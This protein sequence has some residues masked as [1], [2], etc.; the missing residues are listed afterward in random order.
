MI[1]DDELDARLGEA[2]PARAA[3]LLAQL[4]KP[5]VLER[6]LSV[7]TAERDR[8]RVA[9]DRSWKRL[10]L[11]LAVAA[12]SAAGAVTAAFGV[13]DPIIDFFSGTP[14]T[15]D[16]AR[17]FAELPLGAPAG[18]DPRV[19]EGNV[20]RV[21][22]FPISTGSLTLWAGPAAAG[23]CYLFQ[24]QSGGCRQK[25]GVPARVDPTVILPGS[26]TSPFLVVGN[27]DS[28]DVDRIV[29][30]YSNGSEETADSVRVSRPIGATFFVFEVPHE[31]WGTRMLPH[32]VRA[33]R[34]DGSE[35]ARSTGALD[36]IS[37]RDRQI[38]RSLG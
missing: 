32:S 17:S 15:K 38:L 14:A 11:A 23:Y 3:T 4:A 5:V 30:K 31:R 9:R 18:M 8:F 25:S 21:A 13:P 33:L 2:D 26:R 36:A 19:Q 35:I 22:A 6:V 27:I 16:V 7:A 29:V 10:A 34:A 28:A 37:E 12:T 24:D 20:R 1:R